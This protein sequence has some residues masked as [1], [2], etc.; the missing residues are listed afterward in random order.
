[1]ARNVAFS[2]SSNIKQDVAESRWLIPIEADLG[3]LGD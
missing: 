2:V 1:M 3:L